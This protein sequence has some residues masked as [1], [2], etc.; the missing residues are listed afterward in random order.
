MDV[1]EILKLI[2]EISLPKKLKKRREISTIPN[3][4]EAGEEVKFICLCTLSSTNWMCVVTDRKILFVNKTMFNYVNKIEIPVSNIENIGSRKYREYGDVFIVQTGGI[5]TSLSEIEIKEVDRLEAIIR[6]VADI[7][8]KT[9][10]K[11]DMSNE[12]ESGE[13]ETNKTESKKDMSDET[14]S[15]KIE[16]NKIES[17]K[18]ISRKN[19]SENEEEDKKIEMKGIDVSFIHNLDFDEVEDILGKLLL[20]NEIQREKI[21][22]LSNEIEEQRLLIREVIKKLKTKS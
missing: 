22:A 19:F 20:E 7:Q 5:I 11:K 1:R 17:K 16:T 13:I 4:I 21:Q 2:D 15:V 6:E 12:K 14:E 18:Y 10:S 3:Y 8:T 9:E